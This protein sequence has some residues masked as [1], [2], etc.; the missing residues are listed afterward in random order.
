MNVEVQVDINGTKEDVWKVITDIENSTDTIRGIE[1]IEVLEK[2][3]NSFVGLKW[4][5]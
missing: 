2:P 1:K 5:V 3:T 4:R